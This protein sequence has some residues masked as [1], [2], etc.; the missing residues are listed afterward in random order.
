MSIGKR[1]S[2]GFIMQMVIEITVFKSTFSRTQYIFF[3]AVS[4]IQA[5]ILYYYFAV[6]IPELKRAKEE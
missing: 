5:Y 6:E 2:N 4:A 3:G 1:S